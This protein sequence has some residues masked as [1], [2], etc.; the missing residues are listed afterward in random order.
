MTILIVLFIYLAVPKLR[1]LNL[2]KLI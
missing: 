1:K 2:D